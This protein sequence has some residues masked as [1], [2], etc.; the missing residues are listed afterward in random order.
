MQALYRL[1]CD[2]LQITVLEIEEMV[3]FHG[4]SILLLLL[5]LKLLLYKS[6]T[7]GNR[8]H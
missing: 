3:S 4:D 6:T 5:G 2:S 7:V 8:A 1:R